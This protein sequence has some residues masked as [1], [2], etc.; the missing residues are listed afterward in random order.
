MSP[1]VQVS[2]EVTGKV[3][4]WCLDIRPLCHPENAIR[5]IYYKIQTLGTPDEVILI[6]FLLS[7]RPSLPKRR[8]AV[9]MANV[10]A[11]RTA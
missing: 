8:K 3:W 9:T 10:P 2:K 4:T 7:M 5:I 11:K 1:Q 6:L